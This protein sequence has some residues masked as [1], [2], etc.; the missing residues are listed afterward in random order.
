MSGNLLPILPAIFVNPKNAT[1]VVMSV[2]SHAPF[3]YIA[4][5]EVKRNF[6]ELAGEY[7]I[8]PSDVNKLEPI[9]IITVPD[10]GESPAINVT[11]RMGIHKQSDPK[12]EKATKEVYSAEFHNGRMRGNTGPYASLSVQIAKEAVKKDMIQD[13]KASTMYELAEPVHCRCGTEVVVKIFENQWFINY[14]DPLWKKLAH[15]NISEMDIIPNELRH[16]FDNVVDWLKAKACARKAGLGTNLPWAKDWIIEALSDSVIYM[17]YYTVIRSIREIDPKPQD[18]IEDFWDYILLA[19][20][21]AEEVMEKTGIPAEKLKEIRCEFEY[22]YPLDMRHSGRDLI[23]NHLTYMVFVHNAIWSKNNWPRGIVVNGSVLMSGEKMS[24]SLN[25]IIPLINAV[26]RFGA[27]PLRLTLM[28]TA[29]PL[30]DADFSPDLANG[31]KDTL[32]KFYSRSLEIIR[33]DTPEIE[34]ELKNLDYWILSRLQTHIGEAN[35]A[36]KEMKVRKAIHSAL[37]LLNQDMDWYLKR[38]NTEQSDERKKEINHIKKEILKNQVKLLAPFTPHL[39]EEIWEKMGQDSY[40]GFAN[41]P[42]VDET[43]IQK[44]KEELEGVIQSLVEDIRKIIRVTD[45]QP[46]K[47]YFYVADHWKWKIFN[48]ALTLYT[49]GTLDVGTLIKEAFKDDENKTR[50]EEVPKFVRTIV[51]EIQKTPERTI[52]IRRKMMSVNEAKILQDAY[53]FLKNE[54]GAEIEIA[55][56]SDPWK[57]DPENRSKRSKPY[58]PAIYIE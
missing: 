3:D 14:G 26:E 20:G 44:D 33:E 25:N 29:E 32:E 40:V 16:E 13:G 51:E 6:M 56:E 31:M 52:E 34:P 36:M 12:L 46:K 28:I 2:P 48:Q 22:F 49:Q 58:R 8:R 30:K 11:E 55:A 57:E 45:I 17:A 35:D 39:C 4:L 47:I 27:D 42:Q 15:E 21:D 9:S 38:V 24:K 7:N 1:G 19:Q 50:A 37:Y 54:F 23:S 18:L 53:R 43:L 41:W 10:Y 5:E